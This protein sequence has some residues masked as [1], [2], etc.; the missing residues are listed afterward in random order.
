[1]GLAPR[2]DQPRIPI[3]VGGS[4][5]PA[6][7]RVAERGDGWMPQGTPR[8]QMREC[9]HSTRPHRDKVR[10][11]ASLDLGFMAEA[12]YLGTPSWDIGP[13]R[14]TGSPEQIAESL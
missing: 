11:A 5:K 13:G 12:M 2:P 1:M 14:L 8:A 6:L 4:S 10:P 3:W 9:L 7:R